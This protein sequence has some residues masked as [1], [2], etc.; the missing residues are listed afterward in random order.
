MVLALGAAGGNRR[1]ASKLYQSWRCGGRT[2]ASTIIKTYQTPR[3]MGTFKKTSEDVETDILAFMA[4]DPHVSVLY[5][6]A[7]VQVSEL[8]VWRI[9]KKANLHPYRLQLHQ[10]LEDNDFQSLLDFS[11]RIFIKSNAKMSQT[12]STTS[13]FP[14]MHRS[15]NHRHFPHPLLASTRVPREVRFH[16]Q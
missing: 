5:V 12:Y 13:T 9:M 8:T 10:K 6:N 11:N 3:Q 4:A 1:K 16:V 7:D 14:E 15:V 2:T